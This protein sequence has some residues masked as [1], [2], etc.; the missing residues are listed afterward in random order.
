MIKTRPFCNTL[1]DSPRP[2]FLFDLTY[3][4]SLDFQR[5]IG[6]A[7]PDLVT[8]ASKGGLNLFIDCTFD[9]VPHPFTQMMVIMLYHEAT[10]LYLPV[11]HVLQHLKHEDTYIEAIHQCIVAAHHKMDGIAISKKD[12]SMHANHNSHA[13]SQFFVNFISSNA[14]DGNCCH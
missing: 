5:M 6:W 4:S 9:V 1:E 14:Y 10:H 8:L 2:F 12:S 7:H 3:R 11:F 13:L